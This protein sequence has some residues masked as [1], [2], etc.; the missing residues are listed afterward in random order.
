MC[1][2]ESP[3]KLLMSL[4]NWTEF[5]N[6]KCLEATFSFQ[7]QLFFLIQKLWMKFKIR[8]LFVADSRKLSETWSMWPEAPAV[9][10]FKNLLDIKSFDSQI[11]NLKPASAGK[12]AV[13]NPRNRPI[14][15]DKLI[16][17]NWSKQ[18]GLERFS[19]SSKRTQDFPIQ[20]PVSNWQMPARW[21]Q[22]IIHSMVLIATN[23]L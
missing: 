18:I 6:E 17:K 21:S 10:F 1:V 12:H 7:W 15:T 5:R 9:A 14:A 16:Q 11:G 13:S 22:A 8:P 3:M 20:L 4:H 23:S 19:I 2:S